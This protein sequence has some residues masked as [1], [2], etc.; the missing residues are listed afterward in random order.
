EVQREAKHHC[1]S[2]DRSVPLVVADCAR[3]VCRLG[4]RI[5]G[6]RSI[7]LLGFIR[8]VV[9]L[10]T[11]RT[12]RRKPP[13]DRATKTPFV[14]AAAWLPICSADGADAP[15]SNFSARDSPLNCPPPT[16]RLKTPPASVR[17]TLGQ[18]P[19]AAKPSFTS[20]RAQWPVAPRAV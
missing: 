9:R 7:L 14:T 8:L 4:R 10:L 15:R 19:I 11:V 3:C 17:P 6:R 18:G 16:A 20:I 12:H 2:G 1:N 13:A 5:A